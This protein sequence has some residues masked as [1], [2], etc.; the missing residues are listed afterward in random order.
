MGLVRLQHVRNLID[1]QQGA[2]SQ[3]SLLHFSCS[4]LALASSYELA[5][6]E[7][8]LTA[9]VLTNVREH[10]LKIH[11]PDYDEMKEELEATCH[12]MK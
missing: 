7:I 4:A 11:G 1:T 3:T 12:L 2:R 8:D 10:E 9:L 6:A 5:V